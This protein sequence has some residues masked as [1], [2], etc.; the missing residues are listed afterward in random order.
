MQNTTR[1]ILLKLT[2]DWEDYEDVCDELVIEDAIREVADGVTIEVLTIPNNC[3][4]KS[5]VNLQ[6]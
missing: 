6:V 2:V 1:T 3:P 4:C 5:G